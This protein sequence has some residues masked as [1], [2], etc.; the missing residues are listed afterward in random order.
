M[1]TII[2]YD[3]M[4]KVVT[5]VK[6]DTLVTIGSPLGLPTVKK[7]F[8]KETRK[9]PGEKREIR[10]PHN[11][12]TKWYNLSDLNDKVAMHY[13][14]KDDY[15][16]NKHMVSPEDKIV[17]NDY[18]TEDNKNPHK[19]FGYLRTKEMAEVICNFLKAK[20][21]SL[22]FRIFKHSKADS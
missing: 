16:P 18:Q 5:K 6:I 22:F 2:A 21:R 14:L 15:L 8:L 10:T 4:T 17:Y 20:K 7:F 9:N 13:S 12:L 1:G 11:L 19:S 3:V